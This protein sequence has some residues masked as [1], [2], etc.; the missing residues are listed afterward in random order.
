MKKKKK[1]AFSPNF[2]IFVAVQAK[3]IKKKSLK[4]EI[5]SP[6]DMMIENIFKN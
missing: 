3:K 6:E 2:L 1:K 4:T 5:C